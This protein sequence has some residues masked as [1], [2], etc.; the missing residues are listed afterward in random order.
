[1]TAHDEALMALKAA[2]TFRGSHIVI[3]DEALDDI[4]RKDKRLA[5]DFPMALEKGDIQP[6]LQPKHYLQ[7]PGWAGFEAFPR[8]LHPVYG[9][10]SPAWFIPLLEENG[11]INE[12]D[13]YMLAYS[14]RLL[15][16][17]I[18]TGKQVLPISVNLSRSLF[19]NTNLVDD[20]KAIVER[21]GV[22]FN[23]VE[24]EIKEQ[25]ILRDNEEISEKVNQLHQLGFRIAIDDFGTGYF[26][27]HCM[28]NLP[29]AVIKL[30]K[31]MI[32]RWQQEG[33]SQLMADIVTMA[34]H[35]G[36]VV[37]IEG[38]ETEEQLDMARSVGCEIAQGFYYAHPMSVEAC[39][40]FI[41]GEA[42]E[43]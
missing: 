17:W 36:L 28:K 9:R 8:W 32:D 25:S 15:R 6:F 27:L 39:E 38:I 29:P 24:L 41:N 14:C 19:A 11:Q 18:D 35:M 23:L 26:S 43:S 20:L 4:L 3:Y 42:R 13:Q 30:D 1:M 5:A 10:I 12:L 33:D 2:K 40:R 22:P 31:T 37:L 21:Y 34:R 7:R 16:R